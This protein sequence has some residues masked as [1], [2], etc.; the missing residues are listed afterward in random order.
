MHPAQKLA[1]FALFLVGWSPLGA[2]E[3]D[4]WKDLRFLIGKWDAVAE[5]G[6]GTGNF[7]LGV[8]LQGKVLVR[9]NHADLPAA[10]NRPATIHDDLMV[11]HAEGGKG[12]KAIY[13][14]SEGR[15]IH[16]TVKA[17]GQQA[18]FVSEPGAGPRFRLTY[19]KE[20]A[21]TVSVKFEI[22]PPGKPDA[23]RTY[24]EGK[25]RRESGPKP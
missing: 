7:S 3:P 25:V 5:P 4:P 10:G 2:A 6:K 1:L 14:D 21:G 9:K 11:I 12:L 17:D 19:L 18:T 22:A 15:V 8:D 16:Y 24:V 13:F 23:F 20:K